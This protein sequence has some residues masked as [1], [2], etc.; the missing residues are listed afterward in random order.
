MAE[1][2]QL[3]TVKDPVCGMQVAPDKAAASVEHSGK[4][5]YFCCDACAEKFRSNPERYTPTEIDPVCGMKVAPARA[6][7]QVEH[8][9]KTYFFCGKSCA[10]KFTADAD[11][12]LKPALAT[13]PVCH[14]KVDPA[15]AKA[16]TTHNGTKYYFCCQGCHD[17]FVQAPEK[18]LQPPAPTL[19]TLT[20]APKPA[21]RVV[22]P[23]PRLHQVKRPNTSARW[24]PRSTRASRARARSAAWRW[25]PRRYR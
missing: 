24:I 21:P 5:Y 11:A 18:Y 22:R 4:H 23:A 7:G 16:N 1:L 6:A 25:N 14:M 13:D 17:K 9:G 2:T 8:D 15:R 3:G 19:V 10:A 12:Y 20:G